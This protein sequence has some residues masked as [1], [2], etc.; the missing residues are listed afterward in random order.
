M[1]QKLRD[2]SSGWMAT[3]I[4]GLLIIPFAFVGIEQYLVQ[5]ANTA[6]ATIDSPPDWWTSAPAWWPVSV[7]WK[8]DEVTIDQ[9][10][11]RLEEVRQRQAEEQGEAFDARAFENAENKMAILDSLINDHVQR[12]AAERAGLGVSDELVRRTIQDIPAFQVDGKF[13]VERYQ[14]TLASMVPAQ[15]PSQFDQSVRES[16]RQT[17]VSNAIASSNFVTPSELERLI[18]LMGERR[19]VTLLL[20]PPPAIDSAPVSD[21]EIQAWYDSH[22][23]AYQAPETVSIEYVEL[24][25]SKMPTPPAPDEAAL[26]ERFEQEQARFVEQEQRLASHIL[27]QVDAGADAATMAAAEKK[28]GQIAAQAKAE[29]SDFAALARSSSDDTGSAAAGGDLGWVGKDMMPAPFEQALF[30]LKPGQ[31]S[32]PVKTDFGWHVI[33]LREIKAGD[34]ESFEQARDLLAREQAEAD[35]ERAF[36]EVSSQLVDAVLENPSSLA[37]AA[38]AV[39]LPVQKAGPFTRQASEGFAGLPVIKRAAFSPLL[40]EDGTVSD[41][42]ELGPNHSA[43]IRVVSHSP[44]STQPLAKVRDQVI[45]AVRAD[46]ARTAVEKRAD[47][48]LVRLR[49]GESP[50]ALA[51]AEGLD[52]PQVIPGVQRGM[53][54]LEASVSEAVFATQPRTGGQVAAGNSLLSNGAAVLFTV[55]KVTPGD[56]SQIDPQQLDSLQQQVAGVRGMD[57]AQAVVAELRRRMKIEVVEENL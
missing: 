11:Q 22:K 4:L 55:D 45:A 5:R 42:L 7:F 29:G 23:G 50:A 41:P 15:T 28:A 16:L 18:R 49:G 53:P 39:D 14:L 44:A 32:A 35:L 6:V 20:L 10:R 19:D 8:R 48:L 40:I 52:A 21:A 57:D 31:V 47:A 24:D 27:V 33:Q 56:P 36:N 9:F 34:K 1:L 2:K 30:A 54:L 25:A 17:L 51:A 37:Q 3:V 12:I 43:W 38:E 26:R 46:R 13:N